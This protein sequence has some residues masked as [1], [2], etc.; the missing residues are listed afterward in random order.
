MLITDR[1]S[2]SQMVLKK[3]AILE[4]D[5]NS[6]MLS[7]YASM[8]FVM[9]VMAIVSMFSF[10]VIRYSSLVTLHVSVTPLMKMLTSESSGVITSVWKLAMSMS[11]ITGLSMRNASRPS[12]LTNPL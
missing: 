10:H 6:A 7:W 2:P 1:L 9:S 5:S 11:S 12:P 8:F 4:S 3:R